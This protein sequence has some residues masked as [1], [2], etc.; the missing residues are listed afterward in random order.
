MNKK[1]FRAVVAIFTVC[2]FELFFVMGLQAKNNIP[3][4]GGFDKEDA[5]SVIPIQ[6]VQAYLHG[7]QIILDFNLLLSEVM[8]KVTDSEGYVVYSKMFYFPE[9]E[10]LQLNELNN[11]RYFIELQN[12]FGYMS[13]TF[14]LVK[15]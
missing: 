7:S 4:E 9:T 14:E 12:T 5:R 2:F 6:S 11:G 8:V 10:V 15:E 1:I 13:G 3:L